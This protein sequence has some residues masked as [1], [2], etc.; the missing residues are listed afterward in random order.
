MEI[1]HE[2]VMSMEGVL[3]TLTNPY[4]R[5]I[6]PENGHSRHNTTGVFAVDTSAD[7]AAHTLGNKITTAKGFLLTFPDGLP[8]RVLVQ[9]CDA[10]SPHNDDDVVGWFYLYGGKTIVQSRDNPIT[11]HGRVATDTRMF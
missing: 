8:D 11:Q 6:N 7:D 5:Y 10:A 3:V 9:L 2:K 1:I 4:V